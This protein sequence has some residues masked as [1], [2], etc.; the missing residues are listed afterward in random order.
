MGL[1]ELR[2]VIPEKKIVFGVSRNSATLLLE[3]RAKLPTK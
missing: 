3:I 2:V 1:A